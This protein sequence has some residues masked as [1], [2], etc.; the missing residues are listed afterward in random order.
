MDIM[1]QRILDLV[2]TR[3]GSAKELADAL[4][5][6]SNAVTEWKKGRN[7]SYPKYAPQIADY[8][9]VSLD[10]LSGLS[11]DKG[12]KKEASPDE[13]ARPNRDRFQKMASQLTEEDYAVILSVLDAME[14]RK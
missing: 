11:D 5:I 10:W 7:K 6:R 3:H 12:I 1:L 9:G 8:Y 13:P 14:K 4:G 2:G